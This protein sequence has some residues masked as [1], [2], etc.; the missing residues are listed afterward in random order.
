MVTTFNNGTRINLQRDY[1]EVMTAGEVAAYLKVSAGAVR[2]WTRNNNLKGHRLG[3]KGDWRY[4]KS[5]VM[6]FLYGQTKFQE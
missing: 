2:R 3:G 1:D 5:D 6:S 4:F